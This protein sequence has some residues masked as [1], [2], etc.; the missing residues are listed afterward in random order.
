[1]TIARFIA[2]GWVLA[3][4]GL[5]ASA[6]AQAGFAAAPP[7]AAGDTT[8][9]PLAALIDEAL[10]ANPEVR[11]ARRE[12]DAAEQRVAPA[13]ALNDPMLEVGVLNLPVNT[14]SFRQDD[15][16]MKMIGVGQRLPYPGKRQLREE[17][18]REDAEASRQRARE[19]VNRTVRDVRVAYY[20]L[21]LNATTT[22]LVRRNRDTLEQLVRIAQ[23]QYAVGQG[24]QADVLKGELQRSG[25][26]EEL[27]RLARAQKEVAGELDAALGRPPG[28]RVVVPQP[29]ALAS[30][31]LPPPAATD[32]DAI[33]AQPQLLGLQSRIARSQKV[34]AL[35]EKDYYPD[36]D[37]KFAYGQRDRAQDGAYRS[38][39][40]IFTVAINLPVWRDTKLGP[41]VAEA[42]AMRGQALDLFEAQRNDILMQLHHQAAVAEESLASARLYESTILPQ[43]RLAVEASLAAYRVNRLGFRDVLD[44]QMTVFNA[45]I[46]Q[47]TAVAAY[48]K[49]LAEIELLTG[50]QVDGASAQSAGEGPQ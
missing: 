30:A 5:P 14:F 33:A 17:V 10:Q 35:A 48:N 21:A 37:F 50:A 18:A 15:M 38:D 20:G 29:L 12:I 7:P 8:P 46:A 39:M 31:P 26:A 34:L 36:F 9:A 2:L 13:G 47:A 44:S 4:T 27:I 45:E 23:S 32:H 1:M 40:V 25:M 42:E 22:R 16:T 19:T 3:A 11:A 24:S 41:Q 49:A 43:A 28:H 6:L